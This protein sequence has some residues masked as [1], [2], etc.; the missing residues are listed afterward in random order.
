MELIRKI[1]TLDF[2]H[3]KKTYIG[4]FLLAVIGVAVAFQIITQEQATALGAVVAAFT[5]ASMRQA[6]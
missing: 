3:G 6:L 4:S 2:L 1:I 5:A